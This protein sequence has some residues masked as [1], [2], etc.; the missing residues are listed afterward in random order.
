MRLAVLVLPVLLGAQAPSVPYDP[1]D[2]D[3][4]VVSPN[5]RY[6]HAWKRQ[7]VW[8]EGRLSNPFGRPLAGIP[9]ATAG[10]IQ[11]MN[12][13][14]SA[15]AAIL[16]ATPEGSQRIGYFMKESRLFSYVHP[17]DL[18]SGFAAARLPLRFSCGFFPF[19]NTDTLRNG[20]WVADRG[21]ET[22]SVYFEFNLLPGKLRSNVIAKEERGPNLNPIEFY[23]RP[24]LSVTYRGFPVADGQDLILTR[25]GR[26]PWIA[27]PYG[28]ALKA[29]LPEYEKDRDTAERRLADLKKAEAETL[30]PAYEQQMRDHLEKTSGSLRTQNPAK[31]QGRVA[32]MERELAYNREKA[33]REANPQRDQNGNWYWH[34]I[35]AYAD[36]S[37]RLASMTAEEASRPAC[38][39]EV[40]GE[41]GRYAMRGHVRAAGSGGGTCRELV[42]DNYGYFDPKLGRA[43]AQI[44]VVRSLGRCAKVVEGRLV[45]PSMPAKMQLPPQGCYRHVPIWEQMDWERVRALLAP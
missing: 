12:A 19:Y 3:G 4:L 28:R 17:P 7:G 14:L 25:G 44:L 35:D 29:A 36:A 15:L 10:E 24:D 30:S 1:N 2:P 42:M 34:P 18:P 11:Q 13:T 9:A 45:G 27:V 38:F 16:K 5:G 21:G 33:S 41:Q 22:E 20:V 40:P 8:I 43:A 32:S 26:D 39:E 23:P 31:W 6:R 37:R